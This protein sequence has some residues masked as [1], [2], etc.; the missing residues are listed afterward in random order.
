MI[1]EYMEDSDNP[2]RP[3]DCFDRIASGIY[4]VLKKMKNQTKIQTSVSTG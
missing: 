4:E 2:A 1:K 3:L